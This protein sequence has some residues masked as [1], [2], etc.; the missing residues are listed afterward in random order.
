MLRYQTTNTCCSEL[1]LTSHNRQ[2]WWE[3]MCKSRKKRLETSEEMREN[4]FSVT[5]ECWLS[6]SLSNVL[7]LTH[8]SLKRLQKTCGWTSPGSSPSA[9]L[10]T[11]FPVHENTCLSLWPPVPPI[12]SALEASA[13]G[14][15][16]MGQLGS[17]SRDLLHTRLVLWS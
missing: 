6:S 4:I 3:N 17:Q 1:W 11:L 16:F 2:C 15:F 8:C 12:K 14:S 10:H 13:S 5:F 7:A 9:S